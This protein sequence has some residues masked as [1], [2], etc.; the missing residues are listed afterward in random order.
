[1]REKQI[2]LTMKIVKDSLLLHD[3]GNLSDKK[4][5]LLYKF[6]LDSLEN[7]EDVSEFR[8][9]KKDVCIMG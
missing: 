8:F 3:A 4:F 6:D 9:E 7:D 1:M 5:L 2:F